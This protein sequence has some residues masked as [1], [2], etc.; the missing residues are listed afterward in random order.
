MKSG[1]S[2]ISYLMPKP[3]G[4]EHRK[5]RKA[6]RGDLF[7]KVVLNAVANRDPTDLMFEVYLAGIWHGAEIIGKRGHEILPPEPE[8]QVA[9]AGKVMPPAER[10]IVDRIIIKRP[11]GRPR[12]QQ[13]D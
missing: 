10:R 7:R 2:Q 3:T 5:L 9:D 4:P 13:E 12:H 6:M 1:P 8:D 11:R